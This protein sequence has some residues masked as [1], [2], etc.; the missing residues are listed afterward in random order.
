GGADASRR[1]RVGQDAHD[2]QGH[3]AGR[4]ALARDRAQQDARGPARQRVRRF[5]PE[6]R[7]GVLRLLLRLLPARGV[8]PAHGHLYREG[9]PDQRGHRP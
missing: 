7:R 4:A 5:L 2:G 6:Q 9:R 3:R 1:H 8:R